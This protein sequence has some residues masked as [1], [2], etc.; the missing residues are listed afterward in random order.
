[1]IEKQR[2]REL[3][4]KIRRVLM[5]EWDPIG[6]KDE[7]KASDEYDFYLDDVLPLRKSDASVERIASYLHQVETERIGLV[8]AQARPLVP[9]EVRFRAATTLKAINLA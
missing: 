2:L 5:G 1:M 4:V 6:V 3:R 9:I 7:P 8:D